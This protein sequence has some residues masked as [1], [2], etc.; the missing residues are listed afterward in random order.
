MRGK[1]TRG[2]RRIQLLHDLANDDGFSALTRAAEVRQEWR[3]RE[4]MTKHALQQKTTKLSLSVLTAIYQAV[5]GQ[6]V[7]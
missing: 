5:L 1:P 3:H 7:P 4:R 6:P 2:M